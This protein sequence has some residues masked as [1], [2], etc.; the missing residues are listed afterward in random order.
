MF[1]NIR[2]LYDR[3]LVKR[4]EEKEA[5]SA[6]GIIMPDAAQEK[7]QMGVVVAV[8]QGR[9]TDAGVLMTMAVAV[10]DTVFFAKYSGTD[11][12]DDHMILREDDILAIVQ[13]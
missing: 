1:Q 10:G 9:R 7:A 8:G 2:P 12:G 6:G 3:V 11:A 4:I 5:K 13:K